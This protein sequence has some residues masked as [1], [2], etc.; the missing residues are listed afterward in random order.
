MKKKIQ[1]SLDEML[2]EHRNKAYG[3]F[4]L[5]NEY[6][7]NLSRA[8]LFG[9]SAVLLIF[10]GSFVIHK[11]NPDPVIQIPGGPVVELID[12]P[13]IVPDELV[14]PK[15]IPPQK[16]QDK[17][18]T[19]LIPELVEPVENKQQEVGSVP[20]TEQIE[21]AVPGTETHD[22]P[23]M[24][25]DFQTAGRVKI[26][27]SVLISDPPKLPENV[28]EK[29]LTHSEVMP[30][31]PGGMSRMYKWLGKNLRYPNAAVNAGKEGRVVLT[32][33]IEKNGA[34]TDVKILKGI[35]FGCDEEAIRVVKAMP[36]WK[37]GLQNGKPVRVK[38]TLPLFFSL[39]Q[40]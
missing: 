31:F 33:V 30:E 25:G 7:V 37:P 40:G 16:K 4:A 36:P 9:T 19:V 2:F 13:Y 5:R 29:T 15:V 21:L 8:A 27:G 3:A 12:E 10:L 14:P 28:E 26:K 39:T 22:G 1:M 11:L 23:A 17:V 6:S 35:G 20:T 34:I 18:A 24:E 38:Y 32:F